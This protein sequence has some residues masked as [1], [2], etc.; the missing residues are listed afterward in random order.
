MK[1]FIVDH[2]LLFFFYLLQLTIIGLLV[3]LS[4]EISVTLLLYGL[5]LSI[6]ILFLYLSIRFYQ[7]KSFY[8]KLEQ[9]DIQLYD[10]EIGGSASLIGAQNKLMA[11]IHQLHQEEIQALQADKRQQI[12][13]MNQW[14][15]QMKTPVSVLEMIAE[16]H[17][18]S[19]GLEQEI[20]RLHKGLSLA[21]HTAR[22]SQFDKD[23]QIEKVYIGALVQKVVQENK[24]LFIQKELYPKVIIPATVS[25][26]TDSKWFAFMIEQLML[27]A[28][29]YSHEQSTITIKIDQDALLIEDQGIGIAKQDLPRVMNAFYT[30]GN[31]RLFGESTGMGLYLVN[32]IAKKL[33]MTLAIQSTLGEGTIAR[34]Q[35]NSHANSE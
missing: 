24:R 17:P 28:V 12:Q 21:L 4:T 23:Y 10:W 22:Y 5:F 1:L 13:F 3:Y 19:A 7:L 2:L 9:Q 30:G 32:N 31:G 26:Y 11:T 15:H 25:L 14:V 18:E 34:I 27:N 33:L 20:T 16:D 8:G 29:K 35:L 6:L